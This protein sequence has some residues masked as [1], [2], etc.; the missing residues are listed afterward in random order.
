MHQHEIDSH[1]AAIL[2]LN[3][4]WDRETDAVKGAR[5]VSAASLIDTW[6]REK[7]AQASS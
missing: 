1:L 7:A 4:G 6:L 2:K 5:H 3:E